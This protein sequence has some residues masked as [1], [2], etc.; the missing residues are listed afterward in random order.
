MKVFAYK[1]DEDSKIT[2][3][4]ESENPPEDYKFK[5]DTPLD[6]KTRIDEKGNIFFDPVP[7]PIITTSPSETTESTTVNFTP[8]TISTTAATIS[9]TAATV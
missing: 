3:V 4:Y 9:F 5:F 6:P 2:A 8:A 1:T 7:S